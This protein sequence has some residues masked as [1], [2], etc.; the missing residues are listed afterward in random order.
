MYTV[1]G[2]KNWHKMIEYNGATHKV[3]IISSSSEVTDELYLSID[4]LR[5]ADRVVYKIAS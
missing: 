3:W 1:D 4:D 5:N 2:G